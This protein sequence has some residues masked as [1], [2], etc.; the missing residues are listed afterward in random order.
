MPNEEPF[1]VLSNINY[2]QVSLLTDNVPDDD[3]STIKPISDEVHKE[4][5]EE[6]LEFYS[7]LFSGI[8]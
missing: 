2:E 8:R 5:I 7:E 6:R 3:V 1:T 4:E